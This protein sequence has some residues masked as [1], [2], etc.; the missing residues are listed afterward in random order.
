MDSVAVI[1][2]YTEGFNETNIPCY[3]TVSVMEWEKLPNL[4][5]VY[6]PSA[7]SSAFL[8]TN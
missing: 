5:V 7:L 1:D 6:H 8:S 3:T 4:L 2:G